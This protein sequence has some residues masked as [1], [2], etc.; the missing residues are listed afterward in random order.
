M[1]G[2]LAGLG[3][4]GRATRTAIFGYLIACMLGSAVLWFLGL[5]AFRDQIRRGVTAPL[6]AL[7]AW[8]LYVQAAFALAFLWLSVRRFHDQD[9]PGWIALVPFAASALVWAGLP[10]G[11]GGLV[12][13]AFLAGLFLPPTI[14]PNRYG[15][16]PRGWK[17]HDH[18]LQRQ[19]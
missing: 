9:R 2:L 18:Y 12:W 14:G 15:P 7:P 1:P 11:L 19:R 16:D 8:V 17:S 10:D 13:L 6:A 4:A 5:G 3:L